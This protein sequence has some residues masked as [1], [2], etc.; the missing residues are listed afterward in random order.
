MMPKCI[1]PTVSNCV[2][3]HICDVLHDHPDNLKLQ[4]GGTTCP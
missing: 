4:A 2:N 1:R 3:I